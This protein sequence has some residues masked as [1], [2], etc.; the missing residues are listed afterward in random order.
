MVA[1]SQDD[2]E[3][4]AVAVAAAVPILP[5]S[6]LGTAAP[7]TARLTPGWRLL[8]ETKGAGGG[9]GG[10]VGAVKEKRRREGLSAGAPRELCSCE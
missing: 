1:I 6:T 5:S 4:A 10:G 9:G 2:G 7:P 3:V 8:M